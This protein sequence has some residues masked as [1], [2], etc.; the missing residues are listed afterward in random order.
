VVLLLDDPEPKASTS[1]PV[2]EADRGRIEKRTGRTI[3]Q[4]YAI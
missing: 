2:V 1:A 4:C 3:W